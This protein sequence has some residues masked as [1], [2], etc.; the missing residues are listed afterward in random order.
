MWTATGMEDTE[1]NVYDYEFLA[2]EAAVP[3]PI[4]FVGG[5]SHPAHGK[6]V[7]FTADGNNYFAIVQADA[8][9]GLLYDFGIVVY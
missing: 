7:F 1:L 5:Q 4:F 2:F 9:S 8:A 3:M 6:Y